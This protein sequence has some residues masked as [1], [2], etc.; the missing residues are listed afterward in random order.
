MEL[1]AEQLKGKFNSVTPEELM[2]RAYAIILP[3]EVKR[4]LV[5]DN[6]YQFNTRIRNNVIRNRHS[7]QNGKCVVQ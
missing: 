1:L 3:P 4:K 7:I 6:I 2:P 5:D